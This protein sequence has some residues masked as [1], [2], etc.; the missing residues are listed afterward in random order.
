MEVTNSRAVA[1]LQAVLAAARQKNT[2]ISQNVANVST[3]PDKFV[4]RMYGNTIKKQ[5]HTLN[6]I[7]SRFDTYA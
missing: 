7:G 3:K 1:N 6:R 5:E 2:R 4:D